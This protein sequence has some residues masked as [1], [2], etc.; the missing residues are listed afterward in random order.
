MGSYLVRDAHLLT[1]DRADAGLETGDI[2][3]EGRH[4]ADIG[5]SLPAGGAESID[6]RGMI[7]MPGL[8]DSHRHCWG[9]ILRG[10]ARRGN[11]C[12]GPPQGARR[13]A[14]GLTVLYAKL[15]TGGGSAWRGSSG[16]RGERQC[17]LEHELEPVDLIICSPV[18][19]K[20]SERTSASDGA[21]FGAYRRDADSRA[22]SRERP[23]RQTGD[24]FARVTHAPLRRDDVVAELHP[25]VGVGR[26]WKPMLPT[27]RR[28]AR[29]TAARTSHGCSL[30]STASWASRGRAGMVSVQRS[31]IAAPRWRATAVVSPRSIS[32]RMAGTSGTSSRRSVR[33]SGGAMRQR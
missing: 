13:R 18:W 22:A 1:L 26:A 29:R 23:L 28:C 17:P 10:G 2:L 16:F 3:I 30:G 31:G 20:P 7:A 32:S 4:I 12:H 24:R 5:R 19:R 27:T 25:A 8:I 33:I 11:R 14:D 9:S 15:P 21:L 6:G